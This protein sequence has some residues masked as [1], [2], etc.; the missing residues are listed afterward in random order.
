MA[1]YI[2][3]DPTRITQEHVT[4]V[5]RDARKLQAQLAALN[6]HHQ[7]LTNEL[8][9]IRKR[10]AEAQQ[11]IH[12]AKTDADTRIHQAQDD[13]AAILAEA[14]IRADA[15]REAATNFAASITAAAESRAKVIRELA[16]Q[17]AR[18]LG[19][20]FYDEGWRAGR[21]HQ[22]AKRRTLRDYAPRTAA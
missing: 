6:E 20:H 11:Q 2:H 21:D 1:G 8:V 5:A 16:E 3:R 15:I 4:A 10:V 14:Q 22:R 7:H 9:T 12:A 13:A 17:Q 19:E 18:I